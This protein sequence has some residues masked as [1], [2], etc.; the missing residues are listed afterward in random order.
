MDGWSSTGDPPEIPL[1]EQAFIEALRAA[2]S[3]N[4]TDIKAGTARLQTWEGSPGYFSLLQDVFIQ[5]SLPIELRFLSLIQLKNGVDKY[6]RKS[7]TKCDSRS[8][9]CF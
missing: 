1:G 3:S 9:Q 7:A 5:T 8:S 4:I 2:S 6:W